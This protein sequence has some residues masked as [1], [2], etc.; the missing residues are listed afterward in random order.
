MELRDKA[1][2]LVVQQ[3]LDRLDAEAGVELLRQLEV[4]GPERELR[5][6]VEDANGHAYSLM[7]LGSY[8]R[9]ATDDH[10]IRRRREIPLLEEDKEHRYHARH[11]FGAYV[12]H[13]GEDSP[14]VAMLRLLGFFDRPAE[15]KLVSVL[16][17]TVEGEL[18]ELTSPLRNSSSADLRRILRRLSDLRL[19][20]ISAS[21][22]PPIE[23]H[24]LLREYFAEQLRAHSPKAWQAGHRRLF[25]HLCKTTEHWPNTLAGLQPL[26]QAVAHGCLAGLH[27]QALADVYDARILR[28]TGDS[29]F[30]SSNKLGA[31]GAD[32]KAVGCFFARP[33]SLLTEGL[34]PADQAWLLNE[35]AVRLQALGRLTEA[36]EPTR[37]GLEMRV[38]R[39]D[40]RNAAISASNLAD[41]ELIRGDISAA[42]FIGEEAVTYANRTAEIFWQVG[43]RATLANALHQAG[44]RTDSLLLFEEAE[45]QQGVRQPESPQ[46][47]T[48]WSFWYCDLL[49]SSAEIKA[50][51]D[52]LLGMPAIDE[53]PTK[54]IS[55]YE[56]ARERA[57]YSLNIA[58]ANGLLR[59]IAMH[60]LTLARA[61][62][63][64]SQLAHDHIVPAV[65]G[66]RAAGYT[67][68]LPHGLL[69]RAWLRYLSGDENGSKA[70]L[71]E[72]WEI[73]ERGPM[74][75]F[76]ADIQLYRARLFRDRAALAEARR[77]IEK[78]GY[79]R[80]D[81][82]LADA[83]EA[84][85][86]W[87]E[88][89]KS[90][91]LQMD[92][93]LKP[94]EDAVQDQV[95]ISYSHR[96]K[97]YME[98]LRTQLKPFLRSGTV[99][100]WSDQD[101]RSGA[102]WFDEIQAALGKAKAAV[103]LVSPDF[104][105]SDFI[106][107]H[108]LGSLLKKAETGGVKI[109]WVP[110]RPSAHE[111]TPL[112]DY[113]AVTPPDKP[114]VQMSKADRDEAWVRICKEIKR[115]VNP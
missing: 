1:G 71:N 58:E 8:L 54:S 30:Y 9:D 64:N 111:E 63:Y 48:T 28:G 80:R 87:P 72:A 46:L 33:W 21:P 34:D 16:R 106:H 94:N 36:V 92:A 90:E 25:E 82:E 81:E 83:E 43:S 32:L 53:R 112:N 89:P 66:F 101:I 67:S 97:K 26:Y 7:L 3:P 12:K 56:S 13:L 5:E 105:A 78:H 108:E 11:L 99:T 55:S 44:Q 61:M 2:R 23:S 60:H 52:W 88:T 102:K 115:A 51:R 77:L 79:H 47:Y 50:W 10:E 75:L 114:L 35:A 20:D 38:V 70:D 14:E 84:A 4:R 59:D 109:L 68:F 49:L 31:I 62:L 93:E 73:A 91:S 107:D 24:P 86:G 39:E 42:L 22:S 17:E 103:F 57:A 98:E 110:L 27:Q 40:W 74:P 65:K 96:D 69:T 6:A 18:G 113:Q 76:Q 85:K 45:F 104:L 37:A 19:I 95:F 29:G 41:L 15:E 100:A